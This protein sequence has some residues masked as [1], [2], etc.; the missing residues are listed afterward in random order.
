[1][2]TPAQSRMAR[3]A[4]TW[5][6]K[7]LATRARVGV[8]TI[9]RFETEARSPIPATLAAIERALAAAGVEFLD[10]AGVRL[11]EPTPAARKVS[12]S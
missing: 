9:N 10:G 1:M 3:A 11:R 7:D 12:P 5:S 2:I 4:L 8:A 6:T